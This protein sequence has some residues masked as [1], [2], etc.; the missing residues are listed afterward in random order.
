MAVAKLHIEFRGFLSFLILHELGKEPLYGEQL[1]ERIGARKGEKLTPGTIYPALKRLRRF[2]L[3]SYARDGR[4]KV[5]SLTPEG[6]KEVAAL[7][8]LFGRYFAG[9]R[10][11]IREPTR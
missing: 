3:V 4:K 5:Y 9:L 10:S 11:R 8:R 2:K 1:A 6:K 7:Y